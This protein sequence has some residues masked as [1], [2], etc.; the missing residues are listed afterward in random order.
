MKYLYQ[1]TRLK[2]Y[3][4]RWAINTPLTC[5]GFFIWDQGKSM[6]HKSREAMLRS[7]LHQILAQH[8]ELIPVV[9]PDYAICGAENAG[10]V[11]KP[12]KPFAWDWSELVAALKLVTNG[13]FLKQQGI[14]MRLCIFVDG[15]D[16]YLTFEEPN[17][18][19]NEAIKR[20]KKGYREIAGLFKELAKSTICK[21]CLSSR[22]LVEF[23][24]SFS[25]TG[26]QLKLEDLTYED[27]TRYTAETLGH[28][29]RWTAMR[30]QNAVISEQLI[31]GI[32]NKALGVFLWVELV[33]HLLL[34]SLED[35]DRLT[36]L[37]IQVDSMPVEL[38]GENGLYALM[39]RHIKVEHRR[40]CFE[41]LQ[42]VRHSSSPPTLLNLALADGECHDLL[43]NDIN[44]ISP[45]QDHQA[46]YMS[47]QMADRVTSRCAGLLELEKVQANSHDP[48]SAT[49][50][51]CRVR[52]MHQTAKDFVE[53]PGMWK[54]FLPEPPREF[55]PCA[56][57]LISCILEIKL[58]KPFRSSTGG[59]EACMPSDR[60]AR[61]WKLVKDAMV[62]A[63]RGERC[64]SPRTANLS[65]SYCLL[66]F[67]KCPTVHIQNC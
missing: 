12:E 46:Q 7:L 54:T 62:Y 29:D 2:S 22:P 67:C 1:D 15:M 14:D 57:L 35:G 47:S 26:R 59:V 63:S 33:V 66:T 52:F 43:F 3:L 50:S 5:I 65:A 39:M 25:V 42:L 31:G 18:L 27:I 10:E 40:Q 11:S 9:F 28:N 17:L 48:W 38:G 60:R 58:G 16:E 20:R 53:Q 24:D 55:N 21:I 6:M 23:K 19:P 13:L 56:R 34:A 8:K 44:T 36:E 32:V 4:E 49:H 41:I 51:N 45:L 30:A 64:R 61:I 37:Q